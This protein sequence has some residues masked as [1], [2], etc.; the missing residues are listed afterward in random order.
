MLAGGPHRF[1]FSK[2]ERTVMRRQKWL[3]PSQWVERYRVVRMS[4]LPGMWQNVFTP[5]LVGVMDAARFPGVE[6]VILCKTPQTGG[7]EAA[8]NVLAQMIDLSPGPAMVV[9]P[10]E[11][12]AKENAKDRILPMIQDSRHLR[13]YLSGSVDDASSIRINLKHMP[14]YLG[15]SGSVS[16][17]GNKP[18][19]I[20][21]LDELDK[22][23]NPR[24]EATSESL[25]EKRTITWKNRRFIFKLSTPTVED[26]PIWKA[27]TEEAHARFEYHVICPHCGT[28]Q[29]ITFDQIRWPEEERDPERVLAGR[30]AVY[31]CGHCDAQWTD[32]DRDRAVRKGFW[33]EQTSGLELFAHLHQHQPS[34][35]G[36]HLP[37][38]NSYFVS[39]SEIAHAFLKWK[40][41]NR[42]EDL[43]NFMNQYKAEPWKEVRAERKEDS[44]LA[45][46]DDRPRGRV[47]GPQ[48]GLSRVATLVAGV[49]TQA[50]YFRY[51][52]RAFGFGET[53][54]SWLIQ[55]GTAPTFEALSQTLWRNVYTDAEGTE[56]R[57]RACVID[58]MGAPGRTKQVYAW[59]AQQ[60][61]RAM[62]FKGEQRLTA[63]VSY[64]PIE[65]FPDTKGAKIKIPGG[66]LLRRVDTTF[67]KGDL[68]EKLSV[69][70]GDPGAFWLHASTSGLE[71]AEGNS[72]IEYA[73]EMCAE[74]YNPEKLVWENPHQRANHFWDCEVMALVC[75]WELGVRN[76]P[77]P[78]PEARAAEPAP[79]VTPA[80]PMQRNIPRNIV[81]RLARLRR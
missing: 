48:G 31:Q 28:A 25:A 20:L 37:A 33:V 74:V 46:C 12:T 67:F 7:S 32:A 49:D 68:A 70:P 38:W 9:F 34:K 15:W 17:L 22:Y 65:F 75:A 57:V 52:I 54:E 1:V 30:L 18:I 58:A 10:D 76:W 13:G 62:P 53:E 71:I 45:L 51:V 4:S 35:I 73:R 78:E 81:D 19:R 5:Y 60:G 72:L 11:T 40:K 79:M 63:P 77:L 39:L 44:I 55:C 47:P 26:G 14:I 43:K 23:Q 59:C 50:K 21:V 42:L 36:F 2:A 3:P 24:K 29:L 64:S 80:V 41:T 61:G 6:V 56:Y 8:L 66:V 16:R 27:Y 69:A